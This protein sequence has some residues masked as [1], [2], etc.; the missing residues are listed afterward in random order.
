[1]DKAIAKK[2]IERLS[3]I[4]EEHNYR[5][6]VLD[7]PVISDSEY[8]AL[9]KKLVHLEEKFPE[10]RLPD[11]PT[12]RI[13]AKLTKPNKPVVHRTRMYSLD[14]TYSIE[15]LLAWEGR[16]KKA[17]GKEKITYVAE[18]KIDGVSANLLYEKGLL[19]LG[20]TRGD[21][22]TG[23]DITHNLK[24]IPVI[25]LRLKIP[26]Q[27]DVPSLLEVRGEVYMERK[28]FEKLNKE[29]AK[30]GESLFANPRNAAS[31]SVKLLDSRITSQRHLR[32]WVHSFGIVEGKKKFPTQWEFLET[33]KKWG[34][35][36]NPHNRLCSSIK[37]VIAY[38]HESEKI[39]DT[40]SYDAD[41]V[42]VKVNSLKQQEK[43]GETAKSPR[44]AVAFKFS[45][46]Q[47]TTL[48]KRIVVQVGRTGVLTPVADLE[49]VECGGV[50]ISRA[51][52][53]NF[54][55]IKRLNIKEGD[56]VLV[57]RAG[58]VIPKVVKVVESAGVGK[59]RS[60][61]V[62]SKCP[63]CG[64]AVAK[65]SEENVA[66]KCLNPSCPK[67]LER[68]LIHF[69]SRNAM[70]I[71]GLGESV[72][73]QLLEKGLVKDI[74]DIYFLKKGDLLKL[75]LFAE[76]KAENL[77][78]AIEAS[79]KRPLSRLIFALGIPNIGQKAAETLAKRFRS[80]EKLMKATK[81]DLADIH[82]FGSVMAISVV[83]FFRQKPTRDLIK[84][85]KEAG[86]QMEDVQTV[87]GRKAQKLLR[88]KFVF[89]GELKDFTR[90]QAAEKVKAMGGDVSSSVSRNIDFVVVGENPGSKYIKAKELGV[91]IINEQQFKEMTHA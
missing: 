69:A 83:Q 1:M 33:M 38:C 87:S 18:L 62:P 79:K 4:I 75:D 89:T 68:R 58:D 12:Q 31:G 77:L 28:D 55:E 10:L 85:L 56:K 19:V 25:P 13:G 67:Q 30:K 82:E 71:E 37:E 59:G 34:F 20:A 64:G 65:E 80:L 22:V 8:D 17:L 43:L 40:L 47:A 3:R 6:Y 46:R 76:K 52:L 5:Y 54:D 84:K 41:G 29:K 16:I 39:R 78:K 70:D 74:G 36:V 14:N 91:T 15:E 72:V 90:S 11:S 63:V 88:K 49:P 57:E 7:N 53:H 42:V 73:Q 32:F 23:E 61:H 60:V 66:Y 86:V 27:E 81:E 51:T 21:G 24:T 2:E 45:A 26:R 35:P 50:T 9:L 48:V 44:W